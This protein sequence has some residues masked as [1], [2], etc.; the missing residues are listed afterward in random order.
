MEEGEPS[1]GSRVFNEATLTWV[2]P[3]GEKGLAVSVVIAT[4]IT[5]YIIIFRPLERYNLC[6]LLRKLWSRTRHL[7]SNSL[8][9]PPQFSTGRM[10]ITTVLLL[11]ELCNKK[12]SDRIKILTF[13][14]SW[15]N[16]YLSR[17]FFPFFTKRIYKIFKYVNNVIL[18]LSQF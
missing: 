3:R 13:V 4:G 5:V 1:P 6:F 11:H 14:L 8:P 12:F 9:S 15:T 17:N 10:D 18:L 2:V 7:G 16:I